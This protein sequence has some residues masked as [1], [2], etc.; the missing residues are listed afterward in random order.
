[1]DMM[2]MEGNRDHQE[3]EEEEEEEGG[4]SSLVWL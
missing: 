4:S 1:M 2:T 3:E